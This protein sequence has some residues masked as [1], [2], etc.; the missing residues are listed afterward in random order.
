MSTLT[1]YQ[2]L[3]GGVRVLTSSENL[4][5]LNDKERKKE[6]VTREKQ[7]EKRKEIG[8]SFI[9][10]GGHKPSLART[11][12]YGAGLKAHKNGIMFANKHL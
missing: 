8:R 12:R 10:S 2:C 11:S 5:H 4:E 9:A 6:E 1:K 3:R 7:K